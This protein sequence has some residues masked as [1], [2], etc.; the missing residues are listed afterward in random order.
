MFSII[1]SS[2]VIISVIHL[3]YRDWKKFDLLF[4]HLISQYAPLSYPKTPPL[5]YPNTPPAPLHLIHWIGTVSFLDIQST[6][7]KMASSL[8]DP[9]PLFDPFALN[10]HSVPSLPFILLEWRFRLL[11]LIHPPW[12]KTPTP[13]FNPSFLNE[14][15]APFSLQSIH[16]EWNFPAL[17]LFNPTLLKLTLHSPL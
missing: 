5:S 9:L 7:L 13:L 12:M 8:L 3:D 2:L 6:L 11:F 17:S 4:S 1:I 14:P 15:S 10:G 16:L